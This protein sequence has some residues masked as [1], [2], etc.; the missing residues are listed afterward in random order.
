ME[1]NMW[2]R[3]VN[4]K[5][6]KGAPIPTEKEAITGA[7]RLY[8]KAVGRP[9]LGPVKI[10]TGNRYT[11]VRH[12]TLCVNPNRKNSRLSGWPEIAHMISHYAHQR[13]NPKDRPHSDKQ[14]YIERDLTD[15]V[16]ASGFLEGRLVRP[17]KP[18][19]PKD[20]LAEKADNIERRLKA[21]ETKEKRA[22]TALRKLRVQKRYYDKKLAERQ[23]TLN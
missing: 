11:W 14:A 4:S 9:W 3:L 23:F 21:W 15:Y 5:W 18:K 2:D 19:P 8:R 1:K 17:A 20:E 16:L 6:P 13:L 10:V 7:K 12:G 22:K